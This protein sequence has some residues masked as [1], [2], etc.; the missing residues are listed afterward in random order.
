MP[1]LAL[2]RVWELIKD[3]KNV[4]GYS[5]SAKKRLKGGKEVN[6]TRVMR[7]YVSKKEPLKK[8][9]PADVIPKTVEGI[10]IDVVEIGD[11]KAQKTYGAH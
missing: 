5:G 8:L 4:V 7:V 11:V 9:S 10:E 6:G 2:S 1:D 3:K